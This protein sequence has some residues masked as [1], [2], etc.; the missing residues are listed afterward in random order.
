MGKGYTV[1][2]LHPFASLWTN[3]SLQ[4]ALIC[5]LLAACLIS[6][7]FPFP[8]AVN[9][10][11]CRVNEK[12]K[13]RRKE[14]DGGVWIARTRAGSFSHHTSILIL[15][16]P[17]YLLP[18]PVSTSCI[19]VRMQQKRTR[20]GKGHV[21]ELLTIHSVPCPPF[22]RFSLPHPWHGQ[23]PTH[24]GEGTGWRRMWST[25]K[26]PSRSLP[27]VS[28]TW[29]TSSSPFPCLTSHVF[30]LPSLGGC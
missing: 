28:K 7:P 5:I 6:L 12:A 16:S 29:H 8:L 10:I 23:E 20:K 26:L 21:G 13:G 2:W 24:S 3:P 19:W 22:V 30:S 9:P 1:H 17:F 11:I 18:N 25:E 15:F 4:A 14:S 27:P